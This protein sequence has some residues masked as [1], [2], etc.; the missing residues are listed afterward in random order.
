[1]TC[2]ACGDLGLRWSRRSELEWLLGFFVPLR[3]YRCNSCYA[4]QWGLRRPVIN[5]GTGG[6]VLVALLAVVITVR[7]RLFLA[8]EAEEP[9]VAQSAVPEPESGPRV[10]GG[11]GEASRAFGDSRRTSPGGCRR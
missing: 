10:G 7:E 1:M 2:R 11:P 4:R 3:P 9:M 6:I 5:V 8:P